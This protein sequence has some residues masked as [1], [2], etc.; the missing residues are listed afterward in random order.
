M[1]TFYL[2]IEITCPQSSTCS[3]QIGSYLSQCDIYNLSPFQKKNKNGH[4]MSISGISV[5]A[6]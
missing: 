6:E 4:M 5:S 2:G 1:S 3:M